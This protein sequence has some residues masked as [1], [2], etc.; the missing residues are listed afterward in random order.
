MPDYKDSSDEE[1][2]RACDLAAQSDSRRA[3]HTNAGSSSAADSPRATHT[4]PGS[5]SAPHTT[6]KSSSPAVVAML[7]PSSPEEP[8][9]VSAD[10]ET[11]ALAAVTASLA[12]FTGAT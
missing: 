11:A 5:S 10:D 9:A 6:P 7:V 8:S 1:T 2:K 3:T 12:E 4:T